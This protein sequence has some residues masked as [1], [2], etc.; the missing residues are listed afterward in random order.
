MDKKK[1]LN[2]RASGPL[3]SGAENRSISGYAIVFNSRSEKMYDAWTGKEFYETISPDACTQEFIDSQDIRILHNHQEGYCLARSNRGQGTL[4]LNV[5]EVGVHFQFDCPDTSLGN[6]T[7]DAIRRGDI[8]KCSFAFYIDPDG[9]T[10]EKNED[11]TYERTINSILAITEIS[12]LDIMPAYSGTEVGNRSGENPVENNPK[13][14]MD[15]NSKLIEEL[16][17]QIAELEKKIKD[18]EQTQ[19]PAN[20]ET[21]EPR[22]EEENPSTDE[23]EEETPDETPAEEQEENPEENDNQEEENKSSE[24][25]NKK[26]FSLIKAI[27]SVV[28]NGK[29]DEVSQAVSDLGAQELRN[30][31][32]PCTGQIHIPAEERAAVTVTAEG[33][34]VVVT[35]FTDILEP[36]RANNVLADAGARIMTGLV[37]DLQVP[38]MTAQNVGWAGEIAAAA[39]S[40]AAF[41]H[42]LL[43]PKRLT[44]YVD[45]SKQFLVQDSLGAEM[46]IRQDLIN[47]IQ[48]KLEATILGTAAGDSTKPAGIFNGMTATTV[49]DFGDIAEL[50]SDLEDANFNGGFKY[51]LSPKAKAAMRALVIGT[52]GPAGM[53]WVNNEVDG[54]PALTTSNMANATFAVAD[55]SNLCIGQWGAIDLTI[56]PYSQAVNGVVRIT[57]N[58][59]FDAKM[60]RENAVAYG[61]FA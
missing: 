16:K 2:I 30:A 53:V 17:A 52:T 37:G 56:D 1:L 59:F 36:L 26:N 24:R 3:E 8:D 43:Q 28:N 23:N 13:D 21:E 54:T 22:S 4:H 57:I 33:E 15:E 49:S 61:Q 41:D 14:T 38:T 25:M 40:G 45:V 9:Y 58:A 48:T 46:L 7:L 50:E 44:A 35:D 19:E 47:A 6:E 55:W 10:E 39:E 12:L 34:D 11:G 27:R 20:E 5:D 42:V 31:G 18:L 51:I 29:L 60:L 32:L